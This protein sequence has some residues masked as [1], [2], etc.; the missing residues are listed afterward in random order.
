MRFSHYQEQISAL[1][2]PFYTVGQQKIESQAHLYDDLNTLYDTV[3][4]QLNEFG[5]ASKFISK[6]NVVVVK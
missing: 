5:A 1:F 2:L 3:I 4:T 6:R